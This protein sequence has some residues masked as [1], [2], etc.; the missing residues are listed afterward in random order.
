MSW[1]LFAHA[2]SRA[3]VNNAA[4]EGRDFMISIVLDLYSYKLHQDANGSWNEPW[5]PRNIQDLSGIL[6]SGIK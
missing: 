3:S 6:I 1:G 5:Q 2:V 4:I